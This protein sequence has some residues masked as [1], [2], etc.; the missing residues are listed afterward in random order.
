MG[1][2]YTI[3]YFG[4]Y[5]LRPADRNTGKKSFCGGN[6]LVAKDTK[7]LNEWGKAAAVGNK[8]K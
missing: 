1:L 6:N 8:P 4:K 5:L 2:C 7:L 3:K